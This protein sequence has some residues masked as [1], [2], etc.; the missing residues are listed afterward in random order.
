MLHPWPGLRSPESV[1]AALLTALSQARPPRCRRSTPQVAVL[2]DGAANSAWYEHRLLAD[3]MGVPVVAPQD[4]SGDADG[5]NAVVDGRPLPLDVLYRRLGDDE[6]I[7]GPAVSESAN[8][9]LLAASRAGTLAV[10]NTPGNG[11]ADDKAM[12]AFVHTMISYYLG[13]EALIGDVGTWVLADPSQYEG[14]R[15]RLHE[16]VV[17]P[18]DG[19]GGAGVMI[20]PD[21][22]GD[23][24]ARMRAEVDAAPHRFIAQEVIR[25]SSHPTLTAGGLEPR[26]VDLRVFA[27]AGR[28][29]VLV[30]DVA[31]SRVALESEGL[32]VNSS[33]GGGSKD[34][35]I[36]LE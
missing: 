7:D 26:H 17:K 20:G 12:Y 9:L 1:G 32:L 27:L 2:S 13:E 16:L 19:S 3:A 4:L 34:T 30:P 29:T 14:V 24:I 25:F 5:I 6:M 36:G 22:T 15:D 31:L 11:V 28:D 35:W 18:V 23:E 33:Q 21:L 8:A 10:V